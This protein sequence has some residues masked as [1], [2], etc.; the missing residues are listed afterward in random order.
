MKANRELR[1]FMVLRGVKQ[2]EVADALGIAEST[3]TKWM[4]RELSEEVRRRAF[5][6][7]EKLSKEV[8]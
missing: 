7:I 4:R 5:E 3:M 1:E 6:A 2:W 8:K